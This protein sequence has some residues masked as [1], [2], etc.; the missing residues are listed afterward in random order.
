M[1]RLDG[2]RCE[3]CRLLNCNTKAVTTLELCLPFSGQS[4]V[5]RARGLVAAVGCAVCLQPCVTLAHSTQCRDLCFRTWVMAPP[6]LPPA[7]T[8]PQ[9][10][11][12]ERREMKG[13]MPYTAPQVPCSRGSASESTDGLDKVVPGV[14]TSRTGHL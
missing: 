9:M 1:V 4:Q 6:R 14:L 8:Q 10:R 7:P 13:T 2:A 11:P 3:E 5:C 12:R